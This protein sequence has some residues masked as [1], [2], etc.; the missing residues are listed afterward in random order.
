MLP[1]PFRFSLTWLST[2]SDRWT[3]QTPGT[4]RWRLELWPTWSAPHW[5]RR[6]WKKCLTRPY[7]PACRAAAPTSTREGNRST[8]KS[9]GRRRTRW[10][11]CPSHGG[12]GTAAWRRADMRSVSDS[13]LTFSWS[14]F[15]WVW[16]LP[17]LAFSLGFSL[18]NGAWCWA[19]PRLDCCWEPK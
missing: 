18:S 9:R 16:V 14:G 11:V 17:G 5:P 6:I 13:L 7:W 3:Q 2:G 1:R 15:S 10:R 12:R 8:G 4:V 19:G